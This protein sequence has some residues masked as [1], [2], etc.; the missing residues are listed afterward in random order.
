MVKVPVSN[1]YDCNHLQRLNFFL[2]DTNIQLQKLS[3][4][5]SLLANN[6]DVRFSKSSDQDAVLKIAANSFTYD[7]FHNDPDITQEAAEKIKVEWAKNYFM[8][9]RGDWMVVVEEG[10]VIF[11]FLQLLRGVDGALI[12]DLIA[13]DQNYRNKG[14]AQKMISFAMRNCETKTEVVRVGTQLANLPSISLYLK[15]GFT[16]ISA[17][18]VFH[19]HI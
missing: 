19:R 13:V 1:I 6:L 16:V 5:S 17:S 15:M 7:R 8:N 4:K 3:D 18:Y 9:A 2:V 11:G 12:I 10:G 14:A